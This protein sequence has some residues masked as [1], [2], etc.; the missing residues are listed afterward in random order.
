VIVILSIVP[1]AVGLAYQYMLPVVIRDLGASPN[2]VGLLYAGG[3]A[4]GLAAGLIAEPLMQKVGHG[5]A[6]FVGIAAISAGMIVAGVG[7][8][9][10]VA[11]AGIALAQA[12]FVV[13]AS[14][15][16]ALVQALSPARLRGR[17]TSL[18]TLLYWGLMPVGALFE[19]WIAERTNSLVTLIGIGVTL[20]ISGAIAL[21]VRRQILTLRL[22]RDG[23][24]VRGDIRGS[25]LG[26]DGPGAV[27]AN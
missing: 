11:M 4:G 17:L 13:Y 8:I 5:R 14:S 27:G 6:I 3:G 2:A 20:V 23:S 10:P 18:F 22:D 24:S 1:G 12:G 25:G 19:G 7:G 16:V 15:S 26:S 9:V 21:V